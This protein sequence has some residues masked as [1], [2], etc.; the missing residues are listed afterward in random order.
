MCESSCYSRWYA[1][2]TSCYITDMCIVL[3][4]LDSGVRVL[5]IK[6]KTIDVAKP[7]SGLLSQMVLDNPDHSVACKMKAVGPHSTESCI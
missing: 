7:I 6:F 4:L 2:R 3:S 1:K 5:M